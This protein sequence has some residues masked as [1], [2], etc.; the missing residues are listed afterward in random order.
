MHTATDVLVVGAGPTGLTVAVGLARAGHH[1]TI[2]DRQAEGDNTSRAAVVHAR[3]LEVLEPLGVSD[4]LVA[5]GI[6]APRFTIRDRDR[7]LVPIRFDNL[8]TRYPY[9]LMISQAVTERTL[10][11]RFGAL[12]GEVRRPAIL[13]GYRQEADSVVA[14]LDDGDTI[15]ARYLVGADGMHSTVRDIA[16]IG[17]PGDAYGESFALADVVVSG[18]LPEDEVILYFAPEGTLVSA[19]L[20]GGEFRFVAPVPE[21]PSTPDVAFVQELL[22]RRGP[23]S[24]RVKVERVLWGSRFRVHHRIA[25]TY[26]DGRVLIAGDAAHVHSPAGGQGMNIGIQDAAVLAEALSTVLNGG[27]EKVLDE[28]VD[29]RRPVAAEVITLADRLTRMGVATGLRRLVRNNVL[30]V[31]SLNPRFRRMLADRLSGLVYRGR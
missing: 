27:P 17:F 20:P 8:P 2:I 6:E 3:T 5:Q 9:S 1:V 7:T 26:R 25:D 13:T 31:V 23:R 4:A 29:R 21:A 30:R 22:D 12:G 18:G 19:P 16:G 10:L 11:E 14:E 24:H 15:T 28:Y